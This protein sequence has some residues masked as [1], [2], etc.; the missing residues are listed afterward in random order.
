MPIPTEERIDSLGRVVPPWRRMLF[1]DPI[2][3]PASLSHL[4]RE[5]CPRY[6]EEVD[7]KVT[8]CWVRF[9]HGQGVYRFDC[10]CGWNR[11]P[12]EQ[13]FGNFKDFTT[14]ELP[15]AHLITV[16]VPTRD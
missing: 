9:E 8:R 4:L 1:I 12:P 13:G 11:H 7:H 6:Y 16:G 2:A 10:S 5:S 3:R 15:W 14:N